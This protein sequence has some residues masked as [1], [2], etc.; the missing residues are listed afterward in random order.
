MF[1]LVRFL[2]HNKGLGIVSL[3]TK[4][5][6]SNQQDMQS[7]Q[8]FKSDKSHKLLAFG[9]RLKLAVIVPIQPVNLILKYFITLLLL[10]TALR[11]KPLNIRIRK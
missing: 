8:F 11:S 2:V 9:K 1:N 10:Q 3:Q 4:L 5:R 7:I 6:S